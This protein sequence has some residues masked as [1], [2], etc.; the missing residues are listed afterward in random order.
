[1]KRLILFTAIL[2]S[3]V[4]LLPPVFGSVGQDGTLYLQDANADRQLGL[5]DILFQ[6]QI[7]TGVREFKYSSGPEDA[8]DKIVVIAENS[9]IQGAVTEDTGDAE[10]WIPIPGALVTCESETG[11]KFTQKT[12]RSGGFRFE[13]VRPGQHL[14]TVTQTG[15]HASRIKVEVE[16]QMVTTVSVRL[17]KIENFDGKVAGHVLTPDP[18]GKLNVLPEATVSLFPVPDKLVESLTKE[19][20]TTDIPIQKTLT[21]ETGAY[22]LENIP[23][24]R[25]F[26]MANKKGFQKVLSI[27]SVVGGSETKRNLVLFPESSE[28]T[29]TLMG[30]VVERASHVSTG[31]WDTFYPVGG[32]EVT[33][34][35]IENGTIEIVRSGTT[36]SKGGFSFVDVPVG[37]Y[38]LYVRHGKFEDYHEKIIIKS[39]GYSPLPVINPNGSLIE[40]GDDGKN[41]EESEW[42][43]S[44]PAQSAYD[45]L[46]MV[47]NVGSGC[48]CIDPYLNW[49]QDAQ[50]IKIVL[51]RKQMPEKAMLSGHVFTIDGED[52]DTIQ[53]KPIPGAIVI[54]TPYFPY[55]TLTATDDANASL[56]FAPL[57]ELK[58][59]TNEDG[60]YEFIDLPV[61]YPVDGKLTYIITV[62][63]KGFSS[64]K[65]KV[66]VIPGEMVIKNIFLKPE[67]VIASFG[68]YVYDGSVKC[69]D[70]AKCLAPIENADVV[71]YPILPDENFLPETKG[72]YVKTGDD[73]KFFFPRLAAIE[74]QMIVR[75]PGFIPHKS[76]IVLKPGNNDEMKIFLEPAEQELKLHGFVLTHTDDCSD[77]VCEKPVPGA[78]VYLYT[79]LFDSSIPPMYE[80]TVTDENG[81]FKFFNLGEGNYHIM[82][83]AQG[84]EKIEDM[85]TIPPEEPVYLTF[86]LI[87]VA[88]QGSLKGHVFNGAVNCIGGN[89]IMGVPGAEIA[90]FPLL[91]TAPNMIPQPLFVTESDDRGY[92]R[93]DN[94]PMGKYQITAT[95]KIFKPW[96]G[97]IGIEPGLEQVQDITLFP[98]AAISSLKGQVF[99]GNADCAS[100]DCMIPIPNA[101]VMLVSTMNSI[102]IPPIRTETDEKGV[103]I[104]KDIPSGEYQ[105]TVRA[106]EYEPFESN[107]HL[108]AGDKVEKNIFLKPFIGESVLKGM[109]RDGSVRCAT[110]GE[111]CIAPIPGA[112]I[113]LYFLTPESVTGSIPSMETVSDEKGLYKFSGMPSGEFVMHVKAK[114]FM[115]WKDNL[116]IEPASELVF[117]ALLFPVKPLTKLTGQI[118]DG[119]VDCDNQADCIIPIPKARIKL[120]SDPDINGISPFYTE[121]NE[122]GYYELNDIPVGHYVIQIMAEN[123]QE[124][125]DNIELQD[126]ENIRNYELMPARFCK[127]NTGCSK[128][129]FCAKPFAECEGEGICQLRPE[130]CPEIYKPVCGC[131]GN[132]YGNDCEAS[133]NGI[134]VLYEGECQPDPDTGVLKGIVYNAN[135][136]GQA[137]PG[138]DIF[139]TLIVPPESPELSYLMPSFEFFTQSKDGGTYVFERL[140]VGLYNIIVRAPGYQAWKGEIEIIKDEVAEKNIFLISYSEEAS[141]KGI[142]SG[143]IPDCNSATDCLEPIAKALVTLIPLNLTTDIT[144]NETD[145]MQIETITN[146]Q[147]QYIFENLNSGE[148]M[149]RVEATKW[150]LWEEPV[151]VLPGKENLVDVELQVQ[152]ESA[153]LKG[154]VRNG[155]VD[156]DTTVSDCLVGISNAIVTL[157]PQVNDTTVE[158]LTKETNDA[159]EFFF[160]NIPIGFYVLIVEAEGFEPKKIEYDIH[161]GENSVDIELMPLMK[162]KENS[163]CGEDSF[164]KKSTGDCDGEGICTPRPEACIMLYSPVCGCNENTYSNECIADSSGVNVAY[165]GKCKALDIIP[166]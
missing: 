24:G 47:Q 21:D 78:I 44:D 98:E 11:E 64:V 17:E 151:K 123:Y 153:I 156:C 16:P 155:V 141:L 56:T 103:Y 162:C 9:T 61:G 101:S 96:E 52:N 108:P 76:S 150:M 41:D 157:I 106:N 100:A 46:N 134:N 94:I 130:G 3:F 113:Q 70:G 25:Y 161:S 60:F 36:N 49:H 80:K 93:F 63:A 13:R 69:D 71:L 51:K 88:E 147:G 4:L 30:K 104:F 164:C 122:K 84:F 85:V 139:V 38:T 152:P 135:S 37:E 107:V 124:R 40:L 59:E 35:Y 109:I 10:V 19:I 5:Q 99:D 27:V 138:A 58:T 62:F 90:L 117:D 8:N 22:F 77:G 20:T 136:D 65:E 79:E 140:P 115:E 33:L 105:I 92:Y 43:M 6:L 28:E 18:T 166:Q 158:S 120:S 119:M 137:I 95:A 144:S 12:G 91:G 50:F 7:L 54:A 23:E 66:D 67:G 163:E 148:Y 14:L 132:T 26:V 142:V 82:I 154:I 102:W 125:S 114:G 146:E 118:L 74:Y 68:G 34:G 131:D 32:A 81:E 116:K 86:N 143:F 111:R 149:M 15:Y 127:D 53:R 48:F 89:C 121:S 57:P 45:L 97:F 2:L 39:K 73:G 160:E 83:H 29:G 129:E 126:E 145:V 75:A 128:S 87:P 133:A 159:G 112:H 55:P 72:E 110:N 31:V 165:D 42:A 1:M